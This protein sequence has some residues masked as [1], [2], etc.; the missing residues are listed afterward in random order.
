MGSAAAPP[1][2]CHH[3]K[4]ETSSAER[5]LRNMQ[6][7]ENGEGSSPG[8]RACGQGQAAPLKVAGS[9]DRSSFPFSAAMRRAGRAGRT[10]TIYRNRPLLSS[11]EG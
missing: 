3:V 2:V 5:M 6:L 7:C 4:Y 1:T 11:H 10:A 9:C 8:P